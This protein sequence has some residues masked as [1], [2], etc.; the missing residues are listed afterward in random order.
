MSLKAKSIIAMSLAL[1]GEFVSSGSMYRTK[2][3]SNKMPLTDEEL[4][5]LAEFDERGDIKGKK[6]FVKTLRQK[7]AQKTRAN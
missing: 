4:E 3:T 6:K 5:V 7:Y 2:K 1:S